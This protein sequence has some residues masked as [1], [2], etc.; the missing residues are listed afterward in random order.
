M[1]IHFKC[2]EKQ[3]RGHCSYRDAY[4]LKF[5]EA[6]HLTVVSGPSQQMIFFLTDLAEA[7]EL[8]SIIHDYYNLG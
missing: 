2:S 1:H 5:I 6:G 3:L 8:D 4:G 7:V